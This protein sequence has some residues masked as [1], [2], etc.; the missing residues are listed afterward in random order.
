MGC[1]VLWPVAIGRIL[2]LQW[3]YQP[4]VDT[5]AAGMRTYTE[6]DKLR[7][8]IL[9]LVMQQRANRSGREFLASRW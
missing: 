7:A 3:L 2:M 6:V 4:T 1:F 9:D 5:K 8:M